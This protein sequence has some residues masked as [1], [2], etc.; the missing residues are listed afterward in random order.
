LPAAPLLWAQ[1]LPL[2]RMP[3]GLSGSC[4]L[5]FEL[6]EGVIG[7][8]VGLTA[9]IEQGRVVACE[10]GIDPEAG[11]AAAG[12]IGNWLNALIDGETRGVSSDGDWRLP[13]D[14]LG[15]IHETLFGA[16]LG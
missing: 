12:P 6:E 8:P 7:S 11:A 2:L 16:P 15:A 9:R 5:S 10:P 14:L 13:R 4:S 3:N 1:A